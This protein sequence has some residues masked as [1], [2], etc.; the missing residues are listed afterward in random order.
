MAGKLT[1]RRVLVTGAA[2]GMGR[3]I[4]ELFVQEGAAVAAVDRILNELVLPSADGLTWIVR[5]ADALDGPLVG[6]ISLHHVNLANVQGEVGYFTAPWA[7]GGGVSTAAVNAVTE[8]GVNTLGLKRIELY[9][10]LANEASCRVAARCGFDLEGT[11]RSS[12]IYGD[13]TRHDEHV[14]AFIAE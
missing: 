9:H 13:G 3:A 11:L 5:R 10:G 7:R 1:G 6:R 2:S 12:Y 14:H 8:Y 4:A